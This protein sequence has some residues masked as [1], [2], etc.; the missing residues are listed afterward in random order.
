[1]SIS[2]LHPEP[3]NPKKISP[4]RSPQNIPSELESPSNNYSADQSHPQISNQSPK[5]AT[6]HN[7][8][9]KLPE[10]RPDRIIQLQKLIDEGTY[11][12]PPEKLAD[13]L[14]QELQ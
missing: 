4:S 5:M 9:Q 1:M 7:Q 2:S 8:M 12:V 11:S 3:D 13:K 6:Y 14:I 10:T